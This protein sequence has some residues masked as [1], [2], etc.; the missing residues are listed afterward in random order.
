M[1]SFKVVQSAL[2][3][4]RNKGCMPD[5]VVLDKQTVACT[6]LWRGYVLDTVDKPQE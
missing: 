6:G 5:C 1:S 3:L 2:G 4:Y